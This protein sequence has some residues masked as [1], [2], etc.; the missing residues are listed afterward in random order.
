[1]SLNEL[2][3]VYLRY[4]VSRADIASIL[5]FHSNTTEYQTTSGHTITPSVCSK[6][7]GVHMTPDYI[8]NEHIGEIITDANRAASWA[9][10]IFKDRTRDVMVPLYTS[11]VRSHLEFCCPLW[12]PH[13]IGSIQRLENVQREFTRH[14]AGLQSLEYWERLRTINLMSLQRRRERYQIIHI[15]T[16]K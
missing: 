10:A 16:Y 7:L 12:S 8:W 4:K 14:I 3:F 9:L 2:K 15:V 11:F 13:D 5:P 1:M 6:D